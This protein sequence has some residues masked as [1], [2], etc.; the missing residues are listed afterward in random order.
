MQYFLII[1]SMFGS[2]FSYCGWVGRRGDYG[3]SGWME[4]NGS[5]SCYSSPMWGFCHAVACALAAFAMLLERDG[6]KCR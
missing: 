5:S 6:G 3:T 2:F 1:L 4:G